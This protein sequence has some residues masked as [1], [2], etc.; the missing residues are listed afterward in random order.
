[1]DVTNPTQV[2]EL[3]PQS[4]LEADGTY[5]VTINSASNDRLMT[6]LA[7]ATPPSSPHSVSRNK[8]SNLRS[9]SNQARFVVIS[10]NE[11]SGLMQNFVNLR[12]T[13]G[14]RTMLV[15]VEDVYDEFNGGVRSADSIRSFLQ[16]AKQNWSVKPDF[17]LFVGDASFDPRN[18]S[19]FG[20]HVYNRV[21]TMFVD[22]WNMEAVSDE[23][24]A[25]FNNDGVGEIATGRLPAKD[26]NELTG[27]LEKIMNTRPLTRSEINQRGVHFVSDAFTDY[28]FP[29]GSRNMA[30]HFPSTVTVNYLD[31][32]G[33]DAASVRSNIINRINSGPAV[34][35]YFGHASVGTWSGSQIFRSD[36]VTSLTNSQGA[37][38][39]TMINCLNGDY[40]ETTMVSLA[41]AAMKRRFGGASAVWAASGY[42]GAFDQEY[43]TK[44]FYQKV[45][46]GMPLGEAARQTKMLYTNL[47]LRRTYVFFGDPT[48]PL[49][50]Q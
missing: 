12:N 39:M 13:S 15:D 45:F 25:D 2:N 37:P 30:T 18:Y 40:A 22:T 50:A 32:G 49:V 4:R 24:L 31:A 33:Q 35:N 43:Y 16:Y 46:T 17:V 7:A 48:Q 29:A 10:P 36:D 19:G 42:N 14:M 8:P 34:V 6:A 44:D 23:M 3:A 20:G 1:L 11:F 27:M 28:N 9:A 41:E 5:S 38:F 21:P 47:D 26:L